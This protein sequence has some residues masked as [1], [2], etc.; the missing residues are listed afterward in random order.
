MLIISGLALLAVLAG[1]WGL[2][3]AGVTAGAAA[4]VGM[5]VT[6]AIVCLLAAGA[7]RQ[8]QHYHVRH[9]HSHR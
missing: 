8:L 4:S 7:W 1:I 5:I 2:D 9:P 3:L 6:V